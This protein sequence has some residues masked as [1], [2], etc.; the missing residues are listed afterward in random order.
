MSDV[1]T[2]DSS[3]IYDL[4]RLNLHFDWQLV[5]KR[6]IDIGGAV[7]GIIILSPLLLLI[8]G[9][10]RLTSK[11]PAIYRQK[12]LGYQG[13]KFT[14]L[15][16]RSMYSDNDDGIHREYVQKLIQGSNRETNLGSKERPY[17][18]IKRDPRI[19]PL[20][21]ILRKSSL[22]ELPQLFNVITGQMSL[23]GPRP[24]I[25]YEFALYQSWHCKRILE[26]K[27]GITG[28][29]QV[30]GRSQTTFEEM[31]RMD[32]HYTKNWNLWLDCKILCS[33]FKAVFSGNGAE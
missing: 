31:V 25:P 21:S 27:P 9:A 19:T 32:L 23:V 7:A 28:L 20:G 15:K 16:F 10:V 30:K 5:V 6:C 24:A 13:K 4:M 33:T 26:V 8:A 22:D 17:Y 11:G 18:K 3:F 12:R 14:F 2:V 1:I 29:W